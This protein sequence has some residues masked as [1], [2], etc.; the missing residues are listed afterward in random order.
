MS[1]KAELAD[2]TVLEFPDGTPDAVVD[3][4][5]K[6]HMQQSAGPQPLGDAMAPPPQQYSNT[7]N[8]VGALATG[9][10]IGIANVLGTPVDI[11]NTGLGVVPN[12]FYEGPGLNELISDRP[13]EQPFLSRAL[14]GAPTLASERPFGGSESIKSGID[15]LFPG[16]P[17]QLSA[18][19]QADMGSRVSARIGEELGAA[20][21]P[22]LALLKKGQQVAQTGQELRGLQKYF[23]EPFV[24]NPGT[25]VATEATLAAGGGLGAGLANEA[26]GERTLYGDLIGNVLGSVSAGTGLSLARGVGRTGR[27]VINVGAGTM[28]PESSLGRATAEDEV[29]RL[30]SEASQNPRDVAGATVTARNLQTARE[31]GVPLT[32]GQAMNDPGLLALEAERRAAGG[33]GAAKFANVQAQQQQAVRAG[34]DELA[35]TA[36]SDA[37]TRAALRDEQS[38]VGRVAD[39]SVQRRQTVVDAAED[40]VRPGQTPSESG[41]VLREGAVGAI[42]AQK[43]KRDDEA[44]SILREA[45]DA[46][47]EVDVTPV[48]NLIDGIIAKTKRD[49]VLQSLRKVK[50]K[51]APAQ[52]DIS[53]DDK[54]ASDV[55]A[56]FGYPDPPRPKFDTDVRGLHESRKVI[57]DLIEGKGEN[58]VGLTAKKELMQAKAALDE[59]ISGAVDPLLPD[60]RGWSGWLQKYSD[61]SAELSKL[62]ERKA[63]GAAAIDMET[64]LPEVPDAEVAGMFLKPKAKGQDAIEQFQAT[65]GNSPKAKQAMRDYALTEALRYANGDPKKLA[66]WVRNHREAVSMYPD[67]ADDLSTLGKAQE[68]LR[69]AQKRADMLRDAANNPRKSVMAQYLDRST[70][71]DSMNDILSGKNPVQ[72]VRQLTRKLRGDKDA[73]E[74]ARRA[75]FDLMMEGPSGSTAKAA[76]TGGVDTTGQQLLSGANLSNFLKKNRQAINELYPDDPQHVQRLEKIAEVLK[77]SQ[78]AGA[79]RSPVV[80]GLPKK[81]DFISELSS[82]IYALKR[83]VIGL[84][85]LAT[86]RVGRGLRWAY[87]SAKSKQVNQILDEALTNPEL[88]KTLLMRYDENAQKIIGRR[89]RLHLIDDLGF[90]EADLDIRDEPPKDDENEDETR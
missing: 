42:D 18:E 75:M 4:A 88:A 56:A 89:M 7:E 52:A 50:E 59:A 21:L 74:G 81:P 5:V 76:V 36:T 47:A 78:T 22:T 84:P 77:Q 33:P 43:K 83:G 90:T 55:R 86:E 82:R 10:N 16:N 71:R 11:L 65:Y 66:T 29:G 3:R 15:M 70:A 30:L 80:T 28:Y 68:S 69:I 27:D 58:A 61:E 34:I 44:L 49:P 60:G 12:P 45:Y 67:I 35:P 23:I 87:V 57:N 2:G 26:T 54:I 24:K 13:R 20:S 39:A 9:G 48:A 51:L 64:R 40:V 1:I 72:G 8:R 38:R 37:A 17:T 62:T 46:G 85:Y 73:L 41:R 25:A 63:G 53:P 31:Q 79:G 14:G 19:Q 6:Q 32:T